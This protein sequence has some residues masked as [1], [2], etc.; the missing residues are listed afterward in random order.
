M[1]DECILHAFYMKDDDLPPLVPRVEGEEALLQRPQLAGG[2]RVERMY[3]CRNTCSMTRNH[4]R[5]C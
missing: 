1:K 5:S 4:S 2:E 3:A